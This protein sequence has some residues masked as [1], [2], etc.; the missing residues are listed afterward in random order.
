MNQLE[1]QHERTVKFLQEMQRQPEASPASPPCCN[2]NCNQG[3]GCVY[4][5]AVTPLE[6][7]PYPMRDRVIEVVAWV[8]AAIVVCTLAVVL[9]VAG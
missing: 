5:Q 9:G 1:N 3:R 2:C 7:F 6:E 8:A 4:R